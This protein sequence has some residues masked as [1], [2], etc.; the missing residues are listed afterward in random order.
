MQKKIENFSKYYFTDCGKVFSKSR[1]KEFEVIGSKD[2][3][4]YLKITLVDDNGQIYYFRKHRLIA[5]AFY[6]KS[7]LQVNHIDGNILNNSISNLE[8]V[9]GMENQ[10]H[11]RKKQGYSVGV[12]WCNKSKKY[13]AYIQYQKK[14]QHL[15]FYQNQEDA[16]NAYLNRLKQ[17]GITNKYAV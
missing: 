3:N 12:C 8:Y 17:L 15:G 4:G 10:A 5:W 16:K 13:R 6:G 1:G 7:E 14:W 9:T 2:K 11:R